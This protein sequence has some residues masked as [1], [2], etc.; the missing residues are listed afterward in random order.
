MAG[1][2]F[3]AVAADIEAS[4]AGMTAAGEAVGGADPTKDLAS[5]GTALPSSTSAAAATSLSA[6]W[7][8]R[9]D[10]WSTAAKGHGTARVNSAAGY[11]QADHDAALRVQ[12][13]AAANRGPMMA[14]ER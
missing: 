4:A 5:I 10:A 3:E 1:Y 12:A 8:K 13:E 11:T 14:Q 7:T 6:A 9:F 2:T